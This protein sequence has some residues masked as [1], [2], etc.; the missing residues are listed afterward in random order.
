MT[1]ISQVCHP[2]CFGRTQ[3]VSAVLIV[4]SY[5]ADPTANASEQKR[6]NQNVLE[7][8]FG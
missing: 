1:S 2:C 4:F 7:L 6:K 3:P 8:G 5:K